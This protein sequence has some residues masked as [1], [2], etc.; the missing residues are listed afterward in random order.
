M[1]YNWDIVLSK[2]KEL[3]GL[4]IVGIVFFHIYCTYGLSFTGIDNA[5]GKLLIR[6]NIGVDIFLFLSA[7]GLY[8]SLSVN[9]IYIIVLIGW[10]SPIYYL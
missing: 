6:G 2:R 3:F 9:N 8:N 10:L 5:L 1:S 7:I 4:S